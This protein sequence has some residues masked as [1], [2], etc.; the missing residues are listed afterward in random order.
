[1]SQFHQMQDDIRKR[2]SIIQELYKTF[3]SPQSQESGIVQELADAKREIEK[4]KE[5][6]N[7]L[8]KGQEELAALTPERGHTSISGSAHRGVKDK[9]GKWQEYLETPISV[10]Q[11]RSRRETSRQSRYIPV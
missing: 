8:R 5:S 9:I 1:M 7:I 6:T 11:R 4:L 10:S 2:D 3:Q